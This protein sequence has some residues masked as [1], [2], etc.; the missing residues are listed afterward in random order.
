M[1][2]RALVIDD[3]PDIRE[4]IA[5][6]LDR[7]GLDTHTAGNLAEA[8]NLIDAY[9]FDVCL[10]DMRLP[11]GNGVE[12]VKYLQVIRPNLPVAVI[13]AHGNIYSAV[14]AMKNGAFDFVSK[15]IDINLLRQLVT[16]AISLKE[17]NSHSPGPKI[18]LSP[19]HE[20]VS[21]HLSASAS[22]DISKGRTSNDD[23]K[24]SS[25]LSKL[26]LH[27][28]VVNLSSQHSSDAFSSNE[29]T[30]NASLE[31]L[32]GRPRTKESKDSK[33]GA[34]VLIG[35]SQPMQELRSM[36][37]K[38]AKT[39]APVWITGESGTGK[40]LIAHL[41][42]DNSA[43]TNKPFIAVNCGAIPSE[44]MES[45]M[46]GHRKGSF[47]GAHNDHD[48]LF[49]RAEGGT[50]FLDEVAELPLNMQV[51]LLRAI[52]ERSIRRVGDTDEVVT[53]VRIL[54]ASHK[55]LSAE[56][57]TGAF[58]HDLY[59]RLNV[60]C[61]ESP[62][63]RERPTDI[64]IIARHILQ[65]IQKKD[66]ENQ[67]TT[68]SQEAEDQLAQYCFPGNVRELENIIERA[69]TLSET[70]VIE[71]SDLNLT[72][73][74]STSIKKSYSQSNH[75]SENYFDEVQTI[76]NALA[77]TRWNR[78]A[79]AVELGLTYRQLRYRLQQYGIDEK[80]TGT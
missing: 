79:A 17:L 46:F 18:G 78:K 51:K 22:S 6:S 58:R 7:I 75:L 68:F 12:F 2:K 3:E 39:N 34:G 36:I 5:M 21:S 76:K 37:A 15:P 61:I 28:N 77:K 40:E 16:Q 70:N 47:T 63:L 56:V 32:S 73:T 8:K 74:L 30:M 45:E 49:K 26:P 41:I 33:I 57:E 23:G 43:R 64:P 38:V 27:S 10:T 19:E 69:I 80:S 59:Y 9:E 53:D 55:D 66:P 42:H 48:G 71:S 62:S 44:L 50:L 31:V 24:I 11:D 67:L 52:Q 1:S 54:S 14:E 4:L 35:R 29:G 72:N 65:S 60:I 25:N 20:S 13:T